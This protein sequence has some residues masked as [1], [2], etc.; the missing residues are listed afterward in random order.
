MSNDHILHLFST[1][2]M[3]DRPGCGTSV[4]QQAWSAGSAVTLLRKTVDPASLH[5]VMALLSFFSPSI[6]EVVP[7]T[8]GPRV[9]RM[10]HWGLEGRALCCSLLSS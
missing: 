4:Y 3:S 7:C 8:N 1:L 5:P 10:S 2:L 6:L 9:V